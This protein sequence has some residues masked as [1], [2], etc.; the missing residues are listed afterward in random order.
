[1]WDLYTTYKQSTSKNI[2][3]RLEIDN[4]FI[5]STLI[6]VILKGIN[7]VNMLQNIQINLA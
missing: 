5:K 3:R 1:M 7:S 6:H 2:L 4:K